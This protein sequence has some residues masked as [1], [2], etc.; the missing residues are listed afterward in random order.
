MAETN[1]TSTYESVGARILRAGIRGQ[2]VIWTPETGWTDGSDEAART[3]AQVATALDK[4]DQHG[5]WCGTPCTRPDALGY[6]RRP[7]PEHWQA[8]PL[9]WCAACGVELV[10]AGAHCP[11]MSTGRHQPTEREPRNQ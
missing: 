9:R 10:D 8:L 4:L 1:E 7:V 5:P 6:H 2:R 3:A 11:A